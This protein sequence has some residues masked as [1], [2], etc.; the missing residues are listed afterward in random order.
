M[1]KSTGAAFLLSLA[2]LQSAFSQKIV[3]S[4][5]PVDD[6]NFENIKVI[7]QNEDG[8]FLLQSN[9][10]LE[11]DRDRVGFKNRK[12]K[13]S[14]Y[15]NALTAVWGKS[16]EPSPENAS[17]DAVAFAQGKILIIS[18]LFDKGKNEMT[19]HCRWMNNKGEIVKNQA[20]GK[21]N[22]ESGSSYEKV[23]IVISANQLLVALV[24]QEYVNDK[25]SSH[26]IITDSTFNSIR[27]KKLGISYG[28]KNFTGTDYSLS[29]NGDF[30]E[31]G[32]RSI[33]MTGKKRTEDYQLYSSPL[34]SNDFAVFSIGREDQDITGAS[35][36]FDNL[37]NR[38]VC[39]GFYADKT[40]ST[41]AGI[42]YSF[43]EMNNA[44]TLKMQSSP[45]DNQTQLKLLGQRNNSYDI[46]LINYPIRKIILRN[47][48]GAVVIAEAF[49][50]TDYSYY[51]YFSQSYTRRIDYHFNN[52]ITL[53]INENGTIHWLNIIRKEQESTDDGGIFSSFCPMLSD[54]EFVLMY[55]SEISRESEVITARVTNK[56]DQ[57]E[58]R[59]LRSNNNMLLFARNGKQV[60]ESDVIVPCISKK[61]LMLARFSFE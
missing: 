49:Y 28:E 59:P 44:I 61:K 53:S 38:L 19:V 45:I 32:V 6:E 39:A 37:K 5:S 9:L 42:I 18:S 21:I 4:P 16:I 31:L 12:Y 20:A 55:N 46:G 10:P 60:S 57:D 17:V 24:I 3:L 34:A 48:G 54:K 29:N 23:K 11:L 1:F 56:G 43:L 22:L 30:H 27:V 13:V 58:S 25:Q 41:G 35:I 50:T 26:L 51:D 2:F 14:Y 36:I 52:I 8:F 40:T 47:D 15:S 7:G 33:K